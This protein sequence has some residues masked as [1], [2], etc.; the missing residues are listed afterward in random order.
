MSE[1]KTKTYTSE[2][3]IEE[4]HGFREI[5]CSKKY[6]EEQKLGA[7][8]GLLLVYL[9][10]SKDDPDLQVCVDAM[11]MLMEEVPRRLSKEIIGL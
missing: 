11:N 2:S 7:F 3:F 5:L 1:N 8:Q 4:F 9:N 10:V 6:S